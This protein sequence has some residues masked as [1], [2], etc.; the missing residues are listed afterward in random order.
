[1]VVEPRSQSALFDTEASGDQRALGCQDLQGPWRSAGQ[2][3][4]A[5]VGG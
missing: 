2:V 4:S 5:A 1:M 3:G